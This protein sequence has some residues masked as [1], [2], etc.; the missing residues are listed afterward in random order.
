MT[1]HAASQDGTQRLS[2][3]G[4]MTIYRATEL[5]EQLLPVLASAKNIEIDLSGV[6]EIDSAG[7][8]LMLSAK[9]ES[10]VRDTHLSFTGHSKA[11]QDMFDLCDI[12]AFFGDPVF[13]TSP[14][15]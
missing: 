8:Q 14:L 5:R 4:E 12:G 9:L 13:I 2:I 3:E 1:G 11:V 15:H 7:L 6:T 10:I